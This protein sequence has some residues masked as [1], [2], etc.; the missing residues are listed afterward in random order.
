MPISTG[1]SIRRPSRCGAM[2]RCGRSRSP[3]GCCAVRAMQSESVAPETRSEVRAKVP[4]S[5]A[6][7]VPAALLRHRHVAIALR[8]LRRDAH[9]RRANR[10]YRPAIRS[11]CTSRPPI[12]AG[13]WRCCVSTARRWSRR[14]SIARR[15]LSDRVPA[16]AGWDWRIRSNSRSPHARPPASPV[17]SR[18]SCWT[19]STGLRQR[20]ISTG[21]GARRSFSE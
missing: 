20:T 16:S 18:R 15:S 5:C 21:R 17:R 14:A 3:N 10:C 13:I 9:S 4:S 1:S 19:K 12:F 11:T 7:L 6:A 2:P 8:C